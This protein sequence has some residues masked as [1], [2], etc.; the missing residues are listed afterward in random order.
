MNLVTV[1]IEVKLDE[2]NCS[3]VAF[4]ISWSRE[5]ELIIGTNA[6]KQLGVDVTKPTASTNAGRKTNDDGLR[7]S[8]EVVGGP[9][10]LQK[11]QH[12]CGYIAWEAMSVA[13]AKSFGQGDAM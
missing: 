6:L 9:T 8:T 11:K 7:N 5:V 1:Q 13:Q 2:G 12:C 3:K 10:F 4:H